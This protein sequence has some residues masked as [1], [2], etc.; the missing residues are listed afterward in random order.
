MHALANQ[1]INALFLFTETGNLNSASFIFTFLTRVPTQAVG[2]L[3]VGVGFLTQ[4]AVGAVVI[5]R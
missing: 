5:R 2:Q 4:P 1:L 3:W